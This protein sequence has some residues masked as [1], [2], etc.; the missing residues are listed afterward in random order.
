MKIEYKKA[1]IDNVSAIVK[2]DEA[3]A[4][5]HD[6]EC[7]LERSA[8]D[9]VL[10]KNSICEVATICGVVVGYLLAVREKTTY[11]GLLQV[12][13]ECQ[14][15]G[16]GTKLL[17]RALKKCNCKQVEKIRI[18]VRSNNTIAK[19]LYE[20]VGFVP[21][22]NQYDRLEIIKEQKQNDNN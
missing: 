7:L 2:I 16:I 14:K 15:K 9:F 22:K 6:E 20:K 11:I 8:V 10:D 1:T 4:K 21:A 17:K 18:G 12:V 3:D 19:R 5:I 13:P